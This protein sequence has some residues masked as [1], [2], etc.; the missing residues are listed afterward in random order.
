MSFKE[1]YGKCTFPEGFFQTTSFFYFEIENWQTWN[2]D[3]NSGSRCS[4]LT[5][6]S[7][8]ELQALHL[9]PGCSVLPPPCSYGWGPSR[10]GDR[11]GLP[12]DTTCLGVAVTSCWGTE[13]P[14][15]ANGVMGGAQPHT[16]S[17]PAPSLTLPPRSGISQPCIP[18][19]PV[20]LATPVSYFFFLL[21]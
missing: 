10:T 7:D 17:W 11:T 9:L 21:I 13:N 2:P 15:H 19:A 18:L 12:P 20:R 3:S 5:C 16:A 8:L 4:Q 14:Y 1:R 6:T